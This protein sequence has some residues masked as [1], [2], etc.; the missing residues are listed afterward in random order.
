MLCLGNR[1]GPSPWQWQVGVP[2]RGTRA[3]GHPKGDM[4]VQ[5][6]RA[7]AGSHH[8][9][10]H[11][12]MW[13]TLW[14][15][16]GGGHRGMGNILG[17]PTVGD[18]EGWGPPA[19]VKLHGWMGVGGAPWRDTLQSTWLVD[20]GQ[21][22][23]PEAGQGTARGGDT[24]RGVTPRDG[25]QRRT[26]SRV[27]LH[28]EWMWIWGAQWGDTHGGRRDMGVH[29]RVT[30]VGMDETRR[31]HHSVTPEGG[32]DMGV[33]SRRPPMGTDGTGG[34]HHNVMLWGW[35]G[36]RMHSRVRLVGVDGTWGTTPW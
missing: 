35:A 23:T 4:E 9:W 14:S 33:H 31:A 27:T 6:D 18:I 7:H 26:H 17:S 3:C 24:H 25:G 10:G 5:G 36:C 15:P 28:W 12:G 29:S 13:N 19:E 34:A 8:K 20:A 1:K 22:D 16:H 11:R 21:G 2:M 32:W 30:P